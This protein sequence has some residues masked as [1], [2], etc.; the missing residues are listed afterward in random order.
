MTCVQ[1]QPRN[2][3]KEKVCVSVHHI[4]E[5]VGH[6]LV[7]SNYVDCCWVLPDKYK[8]LLDYFLKQKYEL[9]QNFSLIYELYI[10][11]IV[12]TAYDMSIE[13][14][15]MRRYK[16]KQNND[17]QIETKVVNLEWFMRCKKLSCFIP[18]FIVMPVKT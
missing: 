16:M 2:C 12:S 17:C 15:S 4:S 6:K 3:V 9:C 13:I 18:N 1:I 10:G 14:L 7:P 8:N 11:H 5:I